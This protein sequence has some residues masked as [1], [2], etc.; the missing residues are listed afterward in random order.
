MIKD[1]LNIRDFSSFVQVLIVFFIVILINVLIVR[2]LW[3]TALVKHITVLKPVNTLLDTFLLSLAMTM[4][5][6]SC[7]VLA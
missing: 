2:F 7:V 1:F 5:Q 6:G 4:F 3:N